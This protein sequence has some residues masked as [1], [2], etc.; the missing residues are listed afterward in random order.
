MYRMRWRWAIVLACVTACGPW[1]NAATLTG[2]WAAEITSTTLTDP[3]YAHVSLQLNGNALSG[4]WGKS[5]V[6]GTVTGSSVR[7]TITGAEG[8]A[9]GSLT[10]TFDGTD[11]S[12]SGTM[13]GLGRGRRASISQTVAWKLTGESIPPAKPRDIHYD[14]A[15]F[16]CYYSAANKPDLHIFPGDTVHTWTPDDDGVDSKGKQVVAGEDCNIGPIYVEG[17]LPGDTLVVHLLR[18]RTNR[19]TAREGSRITAAA[20]T[21]AY[22][23]AARY[24]RDFDGEYQLDPQKGIA[25]LTKPSAH[26]THYSVPLKPMLGCISVAPAGMA[27]YPGI[28]LGPWGGN[29]DYNE[30][31][32]G[33]TLYFPVSHPG[34]LFGFGDSHAAMGDGEVTLS[35]LETSM[36]VDF[37]VDVIQGSQTPQLRAE[38]KD[39]IMSF[40]VSG[41]VADSIQLATSQLANWIKADYG[42]TDS[43]VAAFLGAYLKYDITELVD[44]HF[45]VVA[46]VPKSGLATLK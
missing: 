43:E 37:S 8:D 19:A 35:A 10:G 27:A 4:S 14:P 30:V 22:D 21:Q 1:S 40:G 7:L 5:R 32:E 25:T 6:E 24:D 38:N 16:F 20:A 36:D 12:G 11:L 26:L 23:L 33:M 9:S 34:A 15:T 13:S 42:L 17:A 3:Q 46:K 41:S 28:D 31:G 44:P 29:L 45:D 39:Y 2:K 18:V